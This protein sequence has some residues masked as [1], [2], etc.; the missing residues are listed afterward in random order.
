[1]A[2]SAACLAVA[3]LLV[4]PGERSPVPESAPA[5]AQQAPVKIGSFT[6]GTSVEVTAIDGQRKPAPLTGT[7]P[8]VFRAPVGATV[9]FT[10]R[11]GGAKPVER[12]IVVRENSNEYT[13]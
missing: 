12:T 1:V 8:F 13:Y 6:P 4:M 9:T 2:A 10:V 3:L 7:A 11:R 5:A